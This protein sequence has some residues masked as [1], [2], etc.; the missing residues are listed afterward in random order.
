MP[1]FE[2]IRANDSIASFS[3]SPK[4]LTSDAECAFPSSPLS[5]SSSSFRSLVSSYNSI[6]F[7]KSA[8]VSVTM[9][10]A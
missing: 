5:S 10:A 4:L 1:C 6:R 3:K 7:V 9:A 2:N 8:F